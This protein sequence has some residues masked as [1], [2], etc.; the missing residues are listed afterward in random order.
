MK[1]K[2]D[3]FKD[4][5]LKWREKKELYEVKVSEM[6]GMVTNEVRS[7]IFEYENKGKHIN[8]YLAGREEWLER[9]GSYIKEKKN[10]QII[11]CIALFTTLV[12]LT[13]NIF[14]GLQSKVVPYIVE[15][16]NLGRPAVVGRAENIAVA[17]EKLIRSVISNCIVDWRT[18]TADIE[19]QKQMVYRLG[20]FFTASAKGTIQEWYSA[21]NP[22]EIAKENK[23]VSVEIKSLPLPV[24]GDTYRV[25]WTE[26]IRS[27]MGELLTQN[28]YQATVSTYI[29]PPQSEESL[30]HNPA[31]IYITSITTTKVL[32]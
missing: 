3:I 6:Q 19:L 27:H 30:L 17:P 21:N 24:G 1:I 29:L 20:F 28:S 13:G 4:K 16:D 12:S 26:T 7:Q 9:Y 2:F 25:E 10:W 32:K 22:Y 31:G 23:L 8:P 11:A 15:V 18:V 5:W 14:Q